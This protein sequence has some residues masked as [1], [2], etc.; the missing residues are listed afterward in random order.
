MARAQSRF[1]GTGRDVEGFG[2][3]FDGEAS[4]V[5][6]FGDAGLLGGELGEAIEGLVDGEDFFP[7]EGVFGGGKH[8]GGR[9]EAFSGAA[10]AGVLEEDAAHH[11]SGDGERRW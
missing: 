4:E 6:E 2:G 3:L 1:D 10:A 11:L 9:G 5:A 8:F 7:T